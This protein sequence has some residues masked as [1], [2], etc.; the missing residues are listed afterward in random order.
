MFAK[1]TSFSSSRNVL[2]GNKGME[3]G[4]LEF[5]IEGIRKYM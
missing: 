1:S 2:A 4:N 5:Y 3:I